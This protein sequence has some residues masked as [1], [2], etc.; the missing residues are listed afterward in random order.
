MKSLPFNI[1]TSVVLFSMIG[2]STFASAGTSTKGAATGPSAKEILSMHIRFKTPAIE[3]A[4]DLINIELPTETSKRFSLRAILQF[5]N[6]KPETEAP[7]EMP[8]RLTAATLQQVIR[9]Q[10]PVLADQLA[11]IT[12]I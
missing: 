4:D 5:E 7:V 12:A 6:P 1:A 9:F 11:D 8:A 2:L 10:A 3:P